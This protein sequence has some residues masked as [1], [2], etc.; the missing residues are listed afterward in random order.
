MHWSAFRVVALS[1]LQATPVFKLK[2]WVAG[3]VRGAACGIGFA[4]DGRSVACRGFNHRICFEFQGGLP[5]WSLAERAVLRAKRPIEPGF[6]K[7]PGPDD[8]AQD[9]RVKAAHHLIEMWKAAGIGFATAGE[10]REQGRKCLA[11]GL[12]QKMAHS[13]TAR[14]N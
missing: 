3:L 12:R 2:Q 7:Q 4:S 1:G 11:N 14:L 13:S 5:K 9:P 6:L 8:W 10:G